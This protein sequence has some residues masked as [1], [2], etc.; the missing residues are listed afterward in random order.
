MLC[1]S[2]V[3]QPKACEKVQLTGVPVVQEMLSTLQNSAGL[4]HVLASFLPHLYRAG[5]DTTTIEADTGVERVRQNVWTVA[6]QVQGLALQAHA[7]PSALLACSRKQTTV[8][9][10][11]Y[12]LSQVYQSLERSSDFSKDMLKYFDAEGADVLLYELRFL[13]AEVRPAAAAY[14]ADKQLEPQVPSASPL[15]PSVQLG[16]HP[17]GLT[18]CP[19]SAVCCWHSSMGR[20]SC[21]L[22]IE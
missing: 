11:S 22:R 6:V 10:D 19:T 1:L 5:Y 17:G 14:I 3:L 16:G 21:R 12:P 8:E 4:W 7:L 18:N 2:V 20:R 13:S 15:Y 9:A